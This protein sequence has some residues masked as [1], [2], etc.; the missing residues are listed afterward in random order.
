MRQREF[1][2]LLGG[3]IAA[4]PLAARAH[5]RKVRGGQLVECKGTAAPRRVVHAISQD[6]GT[7]LSDLGLPRGHHA[8]L[9]PARLGHGGFGRFLTTGDRRIMWPQRPGTHCYCDHSGQEHCPHY[10]ICFE[11][12]IEC[13]PVLG[14]Q[15][16]I[17]KCYVALSHGTP[18]R[19]VSDE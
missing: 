9:F 1:I 12:S 14:G 13:A 7:V 18:L 10:R 15:S 3:A 11:P 16:P 5:H 4:W 2:T 6:V 19:L 8:V 17:V